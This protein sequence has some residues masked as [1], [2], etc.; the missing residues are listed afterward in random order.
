MANRYPEA[1]FPEGATFDMS[2]I[3]FGT[4]KISPLYRYI[5]NKKDLSVS[6]KSSLVSLRGPSAKHFWESLERLIQRLEELDNN[7][8]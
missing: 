6:E 2:T 8:T 7:A 3:Q 1:Q 4:E 5:L